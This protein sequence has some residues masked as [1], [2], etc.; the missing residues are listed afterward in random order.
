[1]SKGKVYIVGAG[2]GS[3]GL[4]TLRAADLLSKCDVLVYDYLVNPDF[5]RLCRRGCEMVDVG[6]APGRHSISQEQILEILLDKA[7]EG[8]Q[9][10]RLKGGDPFIFGRGGE[11]KATLVAEGIEVE[12]VPGVTAALGCA[13]QNGI[14][15]THRDF[16]SSLTLLTGHENPDKKEPQ[17]DFK[18]FATTGGTLCIYMGVG[19]A[20]R[21]TNDLIAGGMSADTPVAIIRWGT[22][23][24]QESWSTSLDK[25]PDTVS[26]KDV[27]AP[28]L[29]L[30]GEA[31]THMDD[32]SE[33]RALPLLGRRIVVTRALEQAGKLRHKLEEMGAEVLELP[34][35]KI[36][37]E[38]SPEVL[39]ETFAG[40]ATY[41]WVI[42]TSTNGVRH[43]FDF[44]FKAFEDLRCLGP[45]RIAAIGDST[46]EEL[47]KLH[48][49]VDVV[50][51]NAVS[52]DL[53]QAILDFE[54]IENLNVLVVTGSRNS[55]KLREILSLKGR[56]IVDEL[57]VYRTDL[58]DPS[59]TWEGLTL[60]EE[61]ADSILFTS[62]STVESYANYL[63]KKVNGD[64][65]LYS[66]GPK[67]TKALKNAELPLAA[68]ATEAS[69]DSL[70]EAL[71]Q[72]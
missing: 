66:I 52:E 57:Q 63:A 41:E 25:L 58:S 5:R 49:Q 64:P 12:I 47:R 42:F 21:I 45:M 8:L 27:K 7:K 15:L 19:Q 67:T 50:P 59:D 71:L 9:V 14:P 37:P 2:P 44:F 17:V 20:D 60:I 46:A 32:P 10:V 4:L 11:E 6:K 3:M 24:R 36:K 54:N 62:S 23:P 22:L 69:L 40:L 55:P 56:A 72:S 1:M 70:I 28:A 13:A 65:K 30:I 34:L 38:T 39:T 43:F 33:G 31:V 48:L 16:S 61:G 35:I 26:S 53:A 68:E 18:K 51:E 29:L